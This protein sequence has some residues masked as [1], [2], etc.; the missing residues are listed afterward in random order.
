VLK[1]MLFT[2][3]K[4]SLAVLLTIGVLG[5][6]VGASGLVNATKAAPGDVTPDKIAQ[7]QKAAEVKKAEQAIADHKKPDEKAKPPARTDIVQ[8]AMMPLAHGKGAVTAVAFSPD[9]KTVAT[10][11]ADMSI[12]LWDLSSGREREKLPSTARWSA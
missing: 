3:L 1:T 9:N 10:A 6:G 7:G 11:G 8:P 5:A 4:I 2:K 12:R